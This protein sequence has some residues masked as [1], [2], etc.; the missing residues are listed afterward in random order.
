MQGVER[1]R[2]EGMKRLEQVEEDGDEIFTAMPE[3]CLRWEC[4]EQ[5]NVLRVETQPRMDTNK[6]E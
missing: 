6:H 3:R 5:V 2:G 4:R 1:E